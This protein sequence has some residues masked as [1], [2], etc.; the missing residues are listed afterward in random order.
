MIKTFFCKYIN[1]FRLLSNGS[2]MIFIL[3]SKR[4]ERSSGYFLFFFFFFFYLVIIFSVR[5]SAPISTNSTFSVRKLY[6]VGTL[7]GQF[8][9]LFNIF[10]NAAGEPTEKLQNNAN[11]GTF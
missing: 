8:F 7:N 11:N 4:N 9:D 6:I 10:F 2:T 1:N 3:D 5:E